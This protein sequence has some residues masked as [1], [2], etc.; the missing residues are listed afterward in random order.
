M[1]PEKKTLFEHLGLTVGPGVELKLKPYKQIIKL[2]AASAI[3]GMILDLLSKS[4]I[5]YLV[6]PMCV[7]AILL[8]KDVRKL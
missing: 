2:L 1:E 7:L 8:I 5:W 6:I 4:A 3:F